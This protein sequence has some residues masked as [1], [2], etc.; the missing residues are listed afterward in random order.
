MV[1]HQLEQGVDRLDP[2]IPAGPAGLRGQG[3]GFVDEQHAALGGLHG[4][5]HLGRGLADV[6]GD[7]TGS[8]DLDQV[9]GPQVAQADE[10]LAHQPRDRG[11]ACAGAA[12]EDA[13][14]AWRRGR[15]ADAVAPPLSV[16]LQDINQ[17][18]DL[19]LHGGEADHAVQFRQDRAQRPN[20]RARWMGG[21]NRGGGLR[22]RSRRLA[23]GIE[24]EAPPGDAGAGQKDQAGVGPQQGDD[25]RER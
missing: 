16:G 10:D 17:A 7:Q 6:A 13:M 19:S 20:G 24:P 15:A 22:G 1:L 14:Q 21:R 25:N 8:I 23:G 12:D 3:V 2:E 11:L 9:A 5:V 4:G 18:R